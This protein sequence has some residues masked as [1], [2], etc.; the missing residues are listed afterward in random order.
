MVSTAISCLSVT[1]WTR[2]PYVT[3]I[4][5]ASGANFF[6]LLFF[7]G[8][9]ERANAMLHEELKFKAKKSFFR[10]NIDIATERS[11]QTEIYAHILRFQAS[12][13]LHFSY[14]LRKTTTTTKTT[15]KRHRYMWFTA[16]SVITTKEHIL[17]HPKVPQSINWSSVSKKVKA[18]CLH[19][20]WLEADTII[21]TQ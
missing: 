9:D 8:E 1:S 15:Q 16:Y 21:T 10:I 19:E 13:R 7:N 12:L 20:L 14:P 5:N 17:Y 6:L 4:L 3:K 2:P 11:L 18:S